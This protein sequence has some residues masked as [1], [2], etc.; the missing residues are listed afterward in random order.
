MQTRTEAKAYVNAEIVSLYRISKAT[1]LA[2]QTVQN[3]LKTDLPYSSET[4]SKILNY[5]N[6]IL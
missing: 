1:K 2:W 6:S 5:L 4:E 3:Y